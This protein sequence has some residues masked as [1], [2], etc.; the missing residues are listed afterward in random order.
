MEEGEKYINEKHCVICQEQDKVGLHDCKG[1]IASLTEYP[2]QLKVDV[3]GSHL[4]DKQ[5]ENQSALIHINCLRQVKNIIRKRKRAGDC[6]AEVASKVSKVSRRKYVDSFNWKVDFL[7]C[8]KPCIADKKHPE[9]RLVFNVTFL[10]DRE[11]I[12]KYCSNRRNDKW[13]DNIK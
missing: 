10:H 8:G 1:S 13:S 6:V 2:N 12:L 9:R 3:L 5:Q 4:L 7:F 11:T